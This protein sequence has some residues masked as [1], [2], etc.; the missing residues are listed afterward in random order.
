MADPTK[1]DWA[2]AV[3]GGLMGL[4]TGMASVFGWFSG[5]LGKVH[6]RI[7]TAHA[8]NNTVTQAARD[9][10]SSINVLE[11]HHDAK[12]QRLERIEDN[13]TAINEKQD[14]QMELLID[15]RGRG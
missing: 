9:P 4:L 1:V 6:E 12:L 11:A 10:A 2:D 8:R 14:R 15:I 5:R 7:D 13:L 3:A